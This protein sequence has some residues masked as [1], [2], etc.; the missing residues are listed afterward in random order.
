MCSQKSS[1]V[2]R[3]GWKFQL[4]Q[5]VWRLAE[6]KNFEFWKIWKYFNFFFR[7]KKLQKKKFFFCFHFCKISVNSHFIMLS[8]F[9]LLS[10]KKIELIFCFKIFSNISKIIERAIFWQLKCAQLSGSLGYLYAEKG[11]SD[12]GVT[13]RGPDVGG[14]QPPSHLPNR[15]LWCRLLSYKCHWESDFLVFCSFDHELQPAS[16]FG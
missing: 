8:I 10:A 7:K 6:T 14:R 13:Q 4:F 11:R 12:H 1:F 16:Q 3:V 9:F 15:G 5:Q 2:V